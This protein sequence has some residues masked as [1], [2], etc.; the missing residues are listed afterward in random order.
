MMKERMIDIKRFEGTI[1]SRH[2]TFEFTYTESK[3]IYEH[4]MQVEGYTI[5]RLGSHEPM[6]HISSDYIEIGLVK[7]K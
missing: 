2:G 1:D 5:L 7:K 6:S 4:C 3:D